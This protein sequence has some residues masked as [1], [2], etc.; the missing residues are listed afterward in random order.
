MFTVRLIHCQPSLSGRNPALHSLPVDISTNEKPWGTNLRKRTHLGG[1]CES[2]PRAIVRREARAG[3]QT[4]EPPRRHQRPEQGGP[5]LHATNQDAADLTDDAPAAGRR[6]R[7][8]RRADSGCVHLRPVER[9]PATSCEGAPTRG[10]VRSPPRRSPT[11]PHRAVPTA[12]TTAVG[13]EDLWC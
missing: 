2:V 10:R 11:G 9:G 3:V 5:S 1:L 4:G 6:P 8:P 13:G 12:R 7:G